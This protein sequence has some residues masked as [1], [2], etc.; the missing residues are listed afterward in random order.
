MTFAR[1]LPEWHKLVCKRDKYVCQ[2]CGRDF[3]WDY[4]FDENGVNQH[5]CG[6]HYPHTQKSHPELKLDI[7]NGKCI[8]QHC[9]NKQHS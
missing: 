7:N 6:H 1:N 9:H 3:N 8:C 5:V 2:F 4:Y